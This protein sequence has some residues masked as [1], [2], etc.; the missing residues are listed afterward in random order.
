MHARA[1]HRVAAQPDIITD[2][3]FPA[4]L[5]G[6][7]TGDRMYRMPRRIDGESLTLKEG[8][9]ATGPINPVF[10]VKFLKLFYCMVLC[11]K[12]MI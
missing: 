9:I 7:I 2:G 5:V 1:D 12:T 4:V 11:F 6:R 10:F 3:H 8:K